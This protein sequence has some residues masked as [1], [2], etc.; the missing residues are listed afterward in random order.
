MIKIIPS[1]ERHLADL[2]LIKSYWLFS[3][4]DY[5]DPDNVSFGT[6]RIFNDDMVLPQNGFATHPYEEM[7]IIS[8]VLEGEIQHQDTIGNSC[9][10]R[11]HEIQRMTAGTGLHHSEWNYGKNPVHF[12][13]IWIPPDTRG[14]APSLSL[15]HI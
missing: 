6:L 13:Q 12:L 14:L 3:F 15:I 4:S 11:Q 1:S 5:Y 9:L 7:E 10:I 8:L 2:G